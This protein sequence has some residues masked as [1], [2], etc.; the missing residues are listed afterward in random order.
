MGD[1]K[2]RRSAR[3]HHHAPPEISDE[4]PRGI[5]RCHR[6]THST[7]PGPSRT[8]AGAG[9]PCAPLARSNTINVSGPSSRLDLVAKKSRFESP[10]GGHATAAGGPN[11]SSFGQAPCLFGPVLLNTSHGARGRT[12]RGGRNRWTVSA[13]CRPQRAAHITAY[14]ACL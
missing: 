9:Q 5:H 11:E 1:H 3:L 6:T 2:A 8:P 13:I 7:G 12:R 4:A 14:F 10:A